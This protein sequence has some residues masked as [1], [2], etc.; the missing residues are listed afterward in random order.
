MTTP[1]TALPPIAATAA[2]F[3]PRTAS[4]LVDAAF[5]LVRRHYVRLTAVA[6]VLWFPIAVLRLAAQRL[7]DEVGHDPAVLR[8][9]ARPV[10]VEEADNAGVE[11]ELADVFH[12]QRL[13]EAFTLV[14]A[15]ARADGVDVAEVVLAL[16]VHQRVAVR[17]RG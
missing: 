6:M 5:Q 9:H 7:G 2:V 4:E 16:R 3:R 17:L 15:T 8:V 12:G 14:V 13:G 1:A 10:G 11:P